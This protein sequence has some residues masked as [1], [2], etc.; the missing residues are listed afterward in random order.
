MRLTSKI[1]LGLGLIVALGSA[2]AQW[3]PG[4]GGGPGGGH[5]GGLRQWQCSQ[6]ARTQ[7]GFQKLFTV[8]V[9]ARHR[10][11]ASFRAGPLLAQQERYVRAFPTSPVV[12]YPWR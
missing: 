11:E 12:C 1:V 5:G 8:Y 10:G 2:Q 9:Q 3:G 6:N 7:Q 4:G